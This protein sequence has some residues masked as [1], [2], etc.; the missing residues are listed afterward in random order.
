MQTFAQRLEA[1][2]GVGPG[3]DLVRLV[4]CYEVMIWHT[5]AL[6]A[7]TP[8]LG[9]ASP[10][11]LPFTMMVPMFFSLSGF[12]VTGSALRLPVG[13]YLLN[14]AA[15][16]FPALFTC[17]GFSML[18]I[19]PLVT[20]LPVADYFSNPGFFAHA[21]NFIGWPNYLLPGV[22]E[23]NVYRAAVN[24]SL[25]TVRWEVGC[26]LMMAGLVVI[27]WYRWP[28][29]PAVLALLWAGAYL[30]V[31]DGDWTNAPGLTGR[32]IGQVFGSGGMLYPFFL[33]GSAIYLLRDRLPW[34][35]SIA[36]ACAL[37]FAAGS[38]L[39]D[40]E[41][42]STHPAFALV[43][44]FPAAYLVAWAGLKPLPVPGP[45]RGGDYSYGV[46]LWHFPVLQAVQHFLHLTEW[47]QLLLVG[48]LPV[49]LLAAA[50]WH[51]M[52]APLLNARRR[53][54]K[55]RTQPNRAAP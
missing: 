4:L 27:G 36:A 42:Y 5:F 44:A 34:H 28:W 12:L 46:Y 17:V 16:I 23:D 14:R 40:G 51:L 18:V 50:S 35:G 55:R 22:F 47:W 25:W 48:F 7:G 52:E 15:R 10:F 1:V 29:L 6:T 9:I 49:T 24:G 19:G 2:G 3:F 30:L 39:L 32:I 13:D 8:A 38:V 43:T 20:S 37:L 53:Q 45:W 41:V 33:A 31:V 21:S 26:Y 11:W 54:V